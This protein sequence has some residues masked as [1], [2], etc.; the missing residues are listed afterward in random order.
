MTIDK[1]LFLLQANGIPCRV[2][3]TG[4]EEKVLTDHESPSAAYCTVART[5][6]G[7]F[8]FF[9]H[10]LSN[11]WQGKTAHGPFKLKAA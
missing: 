6:Y 3:R 8:T 1:V 11:L 4:P 7:E 9:R 2:T 10:Y 5:S